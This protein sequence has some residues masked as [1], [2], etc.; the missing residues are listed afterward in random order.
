MSLIKLYIHDEP[1]DFSKD[2]IDRELQT[3]SHVKTPAVHRFFESGLGLF[4]ADFD[5]L[6]SAIRGMHHAVTTGEYPESFNIQR[7][8]E[9]TPFFLNAVRLASDIPPGYSSEHLAN[10]FWAHL[11]V[12]FPLAQGRVIPPKATYSFS[13]PELD[14]LALQEIG[15]LA[16]I[17]SASVANAASAASDSPKKLVTIR[18]NGKTLVDRKVALQWLK[19]T[20]AFKPGRRVSKASI[21]PKQGTVLVPV[22]KDGSILDHTCVRSKGVQIGRK[23]NERYCPSL[24]AALAELAKNRNQGAERARWRRPNH[25]GIYGIVTAVRWEERNRNEVFG[26]E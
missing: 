9:I 22:A 3:F 1:Q 8:V 7:A 13:H 19:K 14:A 23:G 6:S 5:K 11:K 4:D 16:G 12:S 15:W 21:Y 24:E 18:R 25:Q 2:I 17:S 10:V 26:D 20:P